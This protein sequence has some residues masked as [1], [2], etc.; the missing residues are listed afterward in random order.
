[1][2]LL[3]ALPLAI[4]V[5]VALMLLLLPLS[6]WQRFRSGSAR[7]QARTWL[8][9]L[10]LWLSLASSVLF[11]VFALVASLWWPGAWA[12]AAV[13]L[14]L[15]FVLGAVG[16]VLTRFE[17]L[18]GGLFYKPNV[19]LVLALTLLVLARVV[20][21]VVQGWRVSVGQQHWP[22]E[23]W[24]SHTGL[25]ALAALLLGYAAMYAWLL[26]RRLQQYLRYRGYDRGPR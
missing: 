22:S 18:P 3:L 7:R 10:N 15:G 26:W 9:T 24:M 14:L 1:M 19:W 23:G 4:L 6:L 21:G 13:G 16:Y 2:P 25:L 12:Q 5:F 8:V 20:A 17:A 11:V